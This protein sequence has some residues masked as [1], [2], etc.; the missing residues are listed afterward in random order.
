MSVT[1]TKPPAASFEH[2]FPLEPARLTP[3]NF[4][5][6][7][8]AGE[9]KLLQSR[10]FPEE[11]ISTSAVRGQN[12]SNTMESGAGL[13]REGFARVRRYEPSEAREHDTLR[14]GRLRPEGAE[15][16]REEYST[17]METAS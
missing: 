1:E 8:L 15:S 5:G 3:L 9:S 17:G 2:F 4:V 6:R 13:S 16:V 14:D 10:M 12:S 7:T 11:R